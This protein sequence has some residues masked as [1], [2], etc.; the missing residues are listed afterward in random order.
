[1][2]GVAM[3]N[4]NRQPAMCVTTADLP[5]AASH[6]FYRR[7]NQLL[8]ERE[9]DDLAEAQCPCFYAE[10]TGSPWHAARYLFPTAVDWIF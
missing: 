7:L 1:M 3:G 6:P 5:T 4:R 8:R 9:F 2:R 10:T